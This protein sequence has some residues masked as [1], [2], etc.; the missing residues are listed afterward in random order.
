M[1]LSI[2]EKVVRL[3]IAVCIA[4]LKSRHDMRLWLKTK[5]GSLN[6]VDDIESGDSICDVK[7]SPVLRYVVR[8]HHAPKMPSCVLCGVRRCGEWDEQAMSCI[9][10]AQIPGSNSMSR[11]K[12]M[13]SMKL[14]CSDTTHSDPACAMMCCSTQDD[15]LVS[16]LGK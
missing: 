5:H 12:Y 4:H 15:V 16:D 10:C 13:S 8:V 1:S 9:A 7:H 2:N 6:L 14:W 11:Y 3:D